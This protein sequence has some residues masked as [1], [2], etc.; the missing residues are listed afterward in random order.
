MSSRTIHDILSD[1]KVDNADLHDQG[2]GKSDCID[3]SILE[4][5]LEEFL[6]TNTCLA[7][8]GKHDLVEIA[9]QRECMPG[10]V[11][12]IRWCSRCGSVVIDR[13]VDG[14]TNPGAILK[15]REPLFIQAIRNLFKKEG[16][17]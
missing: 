13:D 2:H 4:Q 9:T 15:M 8:N 3:A 14:R 5:K 11:G 7:N 1:L 10:A 6:R 17:K 12:V 16:T